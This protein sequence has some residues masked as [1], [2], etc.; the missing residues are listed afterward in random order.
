M[1]MKNLRSTLI[2]M[3]ALLLA[4]SAVGATAASKSIAI[5]K[6]V[7]NGV[8][9][10]KVGKDENAKCLRIPKTCKLVNGGM[11]PYKGR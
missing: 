3:L 11:V 4:L 2:L 6:T 8:V 1:P 7:K 5:K 10:W 9:Q